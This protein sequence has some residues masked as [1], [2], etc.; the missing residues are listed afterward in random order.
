[1]QFTNQKPKSMFFEGGR[2]KSFRVPL[3]TSIE[4]YFA[5]KN[6]PLSWQGASLAGAAASADRAPCNNKGVCPEMPP[7]IT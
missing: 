3:G 4:Q 5:Q 2:E 6:Q 7:P 1:M